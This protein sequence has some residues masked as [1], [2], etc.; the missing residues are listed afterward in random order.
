MSFH[1]VGVES[2][3][4]EPVVE[5]EPLVKLARH[6]YVRVTRFRQRP[7]HGACRWS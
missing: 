3:S 6:P 7:L 1:R 5:D 4:G 2:L